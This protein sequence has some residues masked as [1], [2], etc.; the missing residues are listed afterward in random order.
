MVV[1]VKGGM[2]RVR[3]WAGWVACLGPARPRRCMSGPGW[4]W[5]GWAVPGGLMGE[6]WVLGSRG[7]LWWG[8]LAVG[9]RGLLG[10]SGG[11]LEACGRRRGGGVCGARSTLVDF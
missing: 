5:L 9:P 10:C 1:G 6:R 4:V 7:W 11:V 8:G 2:V 3:G